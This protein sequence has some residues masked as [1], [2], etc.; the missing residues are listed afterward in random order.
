MIKW[1]DDLSI[2]VQI[3]IWI[4][5]ILAFCGAVSYWVMSNV[6][7]R[8][9]LCMQSYSIPTEIESCTKGYSKVHR[10]Q[11]AHPFAD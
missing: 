2:D 11:D 3:V 4:S 10:S 7:E 5:I 1:Y 6:N 8:K 9:A